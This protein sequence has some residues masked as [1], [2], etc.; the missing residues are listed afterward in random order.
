MPSP[1][2]KGDGRPVPPKS[3]R[4]IKKRKPKLVQKFDKKNTKKRMMYGHGGEV[5]KKAKPC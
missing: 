3:K 1:Y 2:I 4:R 5:M